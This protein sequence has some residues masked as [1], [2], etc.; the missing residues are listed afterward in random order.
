M[1]LIAIRTQVQ[2]VSNTHVESAGKPSYGPELF[3]QLHAEAVKTGS[4]RTA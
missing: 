2:G 1:P 4:I 3:V